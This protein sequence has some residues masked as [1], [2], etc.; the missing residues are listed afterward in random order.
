M[1]ITGNRRQVLEFQKI[2]LEFGFLGQVFF[3][4]AEHALFRVD[5]RRTV[6]TVDD[7]PDP[8]KLFDRQ[9]GHSHDRGNTE[10]VREDGD[11]RRTAAVRRDD[12]GEAVRRHIGQIGGGD[13]VP[14]QDGA[15]GKIQGRRLHQH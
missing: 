12:A 11:M 5:E 14:D 1:P 3:V 13:L 9:I 4:L 6:V 15:V 7:E 10:C 8:V 2:L